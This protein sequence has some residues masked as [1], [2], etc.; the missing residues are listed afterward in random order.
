MKKDILKDMIKF[1]DMSPTAFHVVKNAAGLLS[2]DSYTEFK[3][4]DDWRVFP[5]IKGYVVRNGSSLIAF[6]IPETRKIKGFNIYSAHSD[7]PSFKLKE[8]PELSPECG[9]IR[10]NTEGY[11][12]MIMSSWFDRPL[13]I[14][15]RVMISEGGAVRECLVN[16]DKDL[17]VIPNVAIHMNPKTNSG[18]EYKPQTDLLPL[19]AQGT[20][21]TK[22]YG[23]I[24][25]KLRAKAEDIISSDLYLYTR[26]KGTVFGADSEFVLSPRLDDQACVYAGLEAFLC[27]DAGSED[28]EPSGY[29]KVLC[30]FDNEE[31]GSSTK[32]GADSDF[33]RDT[34]FRL[35]EAL[36][37]SM[38]GYLKLLSQSFMLSADNAH[39]AHPAL[40]SSAD[41]VNRPCLNGGVVL[42][43]NGSQKYATDAVSAAR[44]RILAKNAE[45]KLQNYANNSNIRGG[46]TLGNISATHVSIPT[47]DIGL[48]Q[49]SMHSAC[50]TMGSKDINGLYRLA[51]EFFRA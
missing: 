29:I 6:K 4:S 28:Y 46:S 9:L 17:C 10:L 51:G 16:L 48:A 15:G 39:A 30:I 2:E 1:T 14:A 41:P 7:S 21:K 35:S 42:K 12:G 13:S 44:V 11:G 20:S 23:L 8:D 19:Y 5:G 31:V 43:F 26:Q 49:L 33:L 18:I 25:K 38:T 34:L 37:E 3:E 22:V 50:E 36:G 47:A 45:I 27:A 24:S 32:Q 40:A